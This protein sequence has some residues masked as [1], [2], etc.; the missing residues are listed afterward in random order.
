MYIYLNNIVLPRIVVCF[1]MSENKWTGRYSPMCSTFFN[2]QTCLF[3][4]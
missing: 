4:R 1:C 3:H 2:W